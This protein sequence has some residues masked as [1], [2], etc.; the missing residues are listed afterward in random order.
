MKAIRAM[1]LIAMA[2]F[3][4]DYVLA[5]V[6]TNTAPE[7]KNEMDENAWSFSASASTYVV[8][9]EREYEQPTFR[10]DRD[11]LHLEARYNYENLETGSVWIGYNFSVGQKL[12]LEA[13]PMLGGV[14]GNTTGIAPG[15][16]VSLTYRKFEFY[17]EGEWV[18]D[19]GDS[20]EN[21]FYS[22]SELS[23][24]PV[25]WFRV[26]LVAERTRVF[27]SDVEIQRGF[28]AGFTY[29]KIDFTTDAFILSRGKPTWVFTVGMSF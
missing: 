16:E 19:A 4:D 28:L 8:P 18:F 21:F 10:A 11:W 22:W 12:V 17:T 2:V 9:D 14:F 5:G 23:V 27:Q 24:S 7:V 26:G 13:T 15:Y 29:K 25:D 1:A 20:A 3:V 6:A